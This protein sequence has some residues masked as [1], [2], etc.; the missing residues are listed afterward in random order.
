MAL[1][2]ERALIQD[3]LFYIPKK[4]N[5][6]KWDYMEWKEGKDKFKS[7]WLD[8]YIFENGAYCI[9]SYQLVSING[10]KFLMDGKKLKGD[11]IDNAKKVFRGIQ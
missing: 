9:Q 1:E 2:D 11:D 6:K 4:E 10:S 7:I 8:N 5:I 3:I